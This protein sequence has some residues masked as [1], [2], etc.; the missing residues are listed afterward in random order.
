[1]SS[2]KDFPGLPRRDFL[3]HAGAAAA[4][5]TILPSGSYG[6]TRKISANSRVNVATIGVGGMGRANL[7]A[8]SSQNIVALCDVDWSYVDR[9]FAE[10]PAAIDQAKQ[11]LAQATDDVQRGR[12]QTQ[13]DGWLELQPKLPKAK[14]FDD[15][16][17]MLEKQK[18][19]DAVVIATPDHG[20]AVQTLAAMDL[21]KHVYVQKP[22]C[23]SVEECRVLAARATSSKLKA[24]SPKCTSGRTVRSRTGRRASHGPP[25]CRRTRRTCR[26]ISAAS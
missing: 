16:R 18:D 23:W 20:H 6:K 11:R 4:A 22:L 1:M 7:H 24:P 13:I 3:R 2:R 9:R 5:F 15:Y 8:L 12:Q 21:G 17:V 14:R 19:V 26:G 25:R 10:I